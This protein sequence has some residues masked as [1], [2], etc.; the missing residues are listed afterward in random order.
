MLSGVS[1]SCV[2]RTRWQR[3]IAITTDINLTYCVVVVI[4]VFDLPSFILLAGLSDE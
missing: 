4:V 2:R 3:H 1:D